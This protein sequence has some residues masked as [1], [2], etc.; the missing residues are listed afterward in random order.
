MLLYFK[1]SI[2]GVPKQS[3]VGLFMTVISCVPNFF[4]RS[5]GMKNYI[6]SEDN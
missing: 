2:I 6:L 3:S 4:L 5:L 1:L